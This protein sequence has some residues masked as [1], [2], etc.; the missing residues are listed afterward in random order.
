MKSIK[1]GNIEVGEGTP[2]RINCN[3]GCNDAEGYAGEVEKLRVI[4]AVGCLPDM[5][6]D[7]SLVKMPTPLYRVI[8]QEVGIPVGTVLSYIPFSKEKGLNWEECKDYLLKLCEDGISFVTIHFTA[9]ELLLDIAQKERQIACTSRG[10]G[11]C[12]Y[13]IRKNNRKQNVFYEH[14]DEIADIAIKYDIVISLGVTF[15]P[16]IIF[17]ACD[18]VH[19]RETEEQL[20]ICTYLQS[21]GVKVMVENVGHIALSKLEEHAELLRQFDAPI[22]PLGPIPTDSAINEDHISSAIG[23]AFA[24]Y[25]RCADIINCVTRYEH[26]HAELDSDVILEAIRAM[27]VVAHTIDVSRGIQSAMNE[28]Y[29]ISQMR[30]KQKSCLIDNRSCNRCSSFCPLKLV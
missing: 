14:I 26:S 13:D 1:I 11:L 8:R 23:A 28:D 12:L 2:V 22:M 10:G 3:I 18:A 21:R 9:H 5:M 29:E 24:G 17:D 30:G 6:M 7:L 25:W 27:R 16:A 19:L 15:R 4:K 20:R